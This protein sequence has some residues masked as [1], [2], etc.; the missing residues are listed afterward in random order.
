MEAS[1]NDLKFNCFNCHKDS[2]FEITANNRGEVR[3]ILSDPND[4]TE[5][6]FLCANCGYANTIELTL[7]MATEV[8]S[9]LSSNNP[10]VQDAVNRAKAGDYSKAFDIAKKRF[11][12]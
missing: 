11:G 4:K 10:E 9:R 12:F 5:V 1:M 8:L 6:T 3:R 2:P 7:E